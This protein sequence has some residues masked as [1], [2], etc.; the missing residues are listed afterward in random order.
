MAS[1]EAKVTTTSEALFSAIASEQ[2]L[3]A[4]LGNADEGLY[5]DFKVKEHPSKPDLGP[6][7]RKNFSKLLSAFANSDGGVILWGVR[8]EMTHGREVASTLQPIS[9]PAEFASRLARLVPNATQ[10]VIDGVQIETI[11]SAKEG[12]GY[13][14]CLI[15]ASDRAPH[16]AMQADREYYGRTTDQT[17]RLEHYQLEDMFGKRARPSLVL[18]PEIRAEGD[19]WHLRL[20][21]RN[22]G[23]V[24]AAHAGW[25]A[26][27]SANTEILHVPGDVQNLSHLNNAYVLSF[28]VQGVIHPMP[29]TVG[30]SYFHIRKAN[31]DPL[32]IKITIFCDQMRYRESWIRL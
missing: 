19:R 30:P 3:T 23:R 2:D 5:R 17:Y 32:E 21:L 4:L 24:S 25:I 14:K 15:P 22:E 16:R 6:D 10:P 18:V 11:E 28:N 8:T 20:A 12:Y 1:V 26:S 7:D 31:S 13:V 9:D 29:I 27:L